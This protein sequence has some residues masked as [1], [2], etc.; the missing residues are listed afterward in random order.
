MSPKKILFFVI[1]GII[2]IW[3]LI[4]TLFLWNQNNAHVPIPK[5][6]KIWISEWT[7][8]SY[9]EIIEG[10]KKYAPEYT[11]TNIQIEKKTTDPVRYRTLLLSTMADWTWPDIFMVPSGE[12]DILMSK[13]EPIPESIMWVNNFDKRYDDIFLSLMYTTGSKDKPEKFYLWV[14]LGYETLWVFYNKNLIKN[15]PKTWNELDALYNEND[16]TEAYLTNLGL[17]S[18]YTPNISE[19][20]GLFFV[21]NNILTYAD[22]K[23][24]HE[25]LKKYFSYAETSGTSQNTDIYTPKISLKNEIEEMD[26]NKYTTIDLFMQ[27]KIRMMFWFPSMIWELEKAKKRT[28][29]VSGWIVVLTEKMPAQ[30]LGKP[31]VNLARFNFFALSKWSNNS[32]VWAKFLEYLSTPEAEGIYLTHNPDKIAAQHEFYT[33]QKWQSISPIFARATLDS[34]IPYEQEQLQVFKYWMKTDFDRFLDESIDRNENID[35]NNIESTLAQG[36]EC[37]IATYTNTDKWADCDKK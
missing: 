9:T 32:S 24:A 12:D 6:M 14:P 2:G 22:I 1:L 26:K 10:F 31:L 19:I 25:E 33:S 28:E 16:V 3:L 23:N 11:K 27:G 20:L 30:S 7:T 21:Q 34:F 18:K 4:G 5:T 35:I 29:A 36:I 17:G 8:E 37:S 15:I 13:I